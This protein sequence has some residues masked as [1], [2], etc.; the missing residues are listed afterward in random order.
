[1]HR[2]S[3]TFALLSLACGT[4]RGVSATLTSLAEL[5]VPIGVAAAPS[6]A[7]LGPDDAARLLVAHSPRVQALVARVAAARAASFADATLPDIEI[8]AHIH[9]PG[10]A[11]PAFHEVDATLD[12]VGLLSLPARRVAADKG[13]EADTADAAA[14]LVGLVAA[15][16][17]ATVR[18]QHA[19]AVRDTELASAEAA[20]AALE[21]AERLF[22]A[23]NIPPREHADR[24]LDA[25]RARATLLVA[26]HEVLAADTRLAARLGL[27]LDPPLA[28]AAF[29]PPDDLDPADLEANA[30]S[31]SL[32]CAA[33]AS[34]AQATSAGKAAAALGL[35]PAVGV[36]VGAEQEHTGWLTGPALSVSVPIGGGSIAHVRRA[37]AEALAARFTASALEA[38]V[39]A[40]ARIAADA[41][42]TA[43]ANWVRYAI[44]TV[45]DRALEQALLEYN[46]MSTGV[47]DL[48]DARRARAENER[49]RLDALRALWQAR[50]AADALR[51]GGSL[52]TEDE[53]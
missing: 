20:L 38:E 21:V 16:R 45:P 49:A 8:G 11:A 47:F 32:R 4:H 19:R 53:P 30:V 35:L 51:A 29:A 2:P 5:P 3:V 15:A 18:A 34:R 36:G 12:V 17:D 52:S 23:G 13:L 28:L 41:L 50:I 40:E 22:A 43:R 33:A 6:G 37:G 48:L 39:R 24:Q 7:P 42:R 9:L 25:D 14:A 27:P 10:A 46:A 44:P 26:E 1:M 31:S